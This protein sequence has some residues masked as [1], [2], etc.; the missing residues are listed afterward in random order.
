M[1]GDGASQVF[2]ESAK[3][4]GKISAEDPYVGTLIPNADGSFDHFTQAHIKYHFPG[5]MDGES[6]AFF[7][8]GYMGNLQYMEEPNGNRLTP[9]YDGGGNI[10]AHT[11]RRGIPS[12]M[13]SVTQHRGAADLVTAFG[14]DENGNRR[15]VRNAKGQETNVTY[16]SLDR[17]RTVQFPS[18]ATIGPVQQ[19]YDYDPEGNVTSVSE[20]AAAAVSRAATREPTTTATAS[21][22]RPSRRTA[23]ASGA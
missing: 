22:R 13:T 1:G 12:R 15:F 17:P 9:T 14:Y 19:Q 5:A 11:D 4:D 21:R 7:N 20:T 10:T 18:A 2:N 3:R 23:P 16:D 6:T 8:S